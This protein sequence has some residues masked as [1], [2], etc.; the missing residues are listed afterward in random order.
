[1]VGVSEC[2]I[3]KRVDLTSTIKGDD[4]YLQTLKVDKNDRD[5]TVIELDNVKNN[6]DSNQI[7]KIFLKSG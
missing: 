5:V 2:K 1:M 6:L 4:F 3:K 7:K